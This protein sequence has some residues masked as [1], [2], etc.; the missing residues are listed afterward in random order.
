VYCF[1]YGG[2]IGQALALEQPELIRS[3]TLANSLHSPGM[4]QANHA[5]INREIAN[6]FPEVWDRIERLRREGVPSTDRAPYP[7]MQREFVRY[8]PRARLHVLERSGSFGHL[9]EPDAV[10][11]HLR[12]FWAQPA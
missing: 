5:N 8:A 1:S 6:Q 12:K 3:L 10:F 2:L 11:E 4:W 7:A 9:E